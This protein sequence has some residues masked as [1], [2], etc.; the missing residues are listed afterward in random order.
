MRDELLKLPHQPDIDIVL[1]S[2]VLELAAFLHGRK[3]STI[4][5][6][7]FPRFGTALLYIAGQQ[8]EL[9]TARKESYSSES[10]K[11]KVNAATLAEDALRRDFTFN[12]LMRNL[13]TGEL[14][15]PLGVGLADLN[16]KVLRTPLDPGETFRDDP[17]RMLRAVRFRNRFGFSPAQG[18]YEAI[19]RESER[20]QI[21]SAERIRDEFVKMLLHQSAPQSLD[22]LMKLGLLQKFFPE[23]EEGLNVDQG[24]YHLKDVWNHTLDVVSQA[25][26]RAKSLHTENDS[27]DASPAL[28][29]MLGALFHD[30]GKP[31]T[32]SVDDDGRIR[33]FNHEKVGAQLAFTMLMRLKFNRR[34]SSAVSSIVANHMRLG[35]AVP[36]TA[37]AARRLIRDMDDLLEPLLLVCEADAGSLRAAPKGVRFDQ[38]RSRIKEISENVP[39]SELK[40]PLTGSEIMNAL[41]LPPGAEIG[42][43]KERLTE[44]VLE[45]TLAAD[46]KETALEMIKKFAQ[47]G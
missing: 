47:D 15:D 46:D 36:F 44:A 5:P 11:P 26:Q 6:V 21:V 24:S 37:S 14:L 27:S 23:F 18:V 43:I 3:L 22:D 32:R 30:V 10:R 12:T 34:T 8:V 42:K 40:S 17:L 31:R 45:G 7:V 16:A 13:H 39:R 20:L 28:V 19:E 33:F 41:S 9:V 35:S 4:A 38:V 29:V 2:D 1:E 25:W